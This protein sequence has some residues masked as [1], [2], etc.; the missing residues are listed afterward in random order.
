MYFY[1]CLPVFQ[2]K[3]QVKFFENLFPSPK[4]KGVEETMLLYLLHYILYIAYL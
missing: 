1:S 3:L 4:A 2:S